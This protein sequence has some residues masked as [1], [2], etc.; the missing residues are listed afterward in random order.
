ME[1]FSIFPDEPGPDFLGRWSSERR[2]YGIYHLLRCRDLMDGDFAKPAEV[3]H[4]KYLAVG[5][6]SPSKRGR[7]PKPPTHRP[8]GAPP[9]HGG[10]ADGWIATAPEVHGGEFAEVCTSMGSA[11]AWWQVYSQDDIIVRKDVSLFSE[12]LRRVKP[13][14][15]IQ[16]AGLAKR[17]ISGDIRGL[18]RIPVRPDGWVTA[19]AQAAGGP[20]FL[21]RAHA[22]L[23]RV[24]YES[25]T[26][27]GDI[28]V[29]AGA[30]LESREVAV[31]RRGDL[32]EQAGPQVQHGGVL[33]MPVVVPESAAPL[34][35]GP[36]AAAYLAAA[37]AAQDGPAGRGAAAQPFGAGRPPRPGTTGWVTVD[38]RN[39][40]GPV[41][42]EMLEA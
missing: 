29:R 8:G 16:Q 2:V 18:V 33:R 32:L 13:G 24:V 22:P 39:A 1:D 12:E 28:L 23:W 11:G 6:R 5:A 31:L 42:L 20:R 40:G 10:G 3:A 37:G 14:M 30:D 15:R 34:Q 35:G 38:A 25:G 4:L 9:P 41:F 17:F 36:A 7:A 21:E 27:H 26:P 19:D